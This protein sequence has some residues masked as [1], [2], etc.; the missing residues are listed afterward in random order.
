MAAI[1]AATR[2]RTAVIIARRATTERAL[3]IYMRT[4][5]RR[6]GGIAPIRII[7]TPTRAAPARISISIPPR[8]IITAPARAAGPIPII[9]VIVA[10][11]HV[12][13]GARVAIVPRIPRI[14]ALPVIAA[15]VEIVVD[16]N[17]RDLIIVAIAALLVL[18]IARLF[19]SRLARF[20]TI[21][22]AVGLGHLRV[23]TRKRE[24]HEHGS[25]GKHISFEFHKP[26]P[27]SKGCKGDE[28]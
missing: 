14:P 23:T 21:F 9:V 19:R 26:A 22:A 20:G 18:I 15:I 5:A 7:P 25:E 10:G 28:E 6:V 2:D 27:F 13:P 16:I 1:G 11:A 3:L 12:P 24:R 17:V 8:I 4:T